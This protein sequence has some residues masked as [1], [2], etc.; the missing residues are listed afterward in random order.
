MI[1]KPLPGAPDSGVKVFGIMKL[2]PQVS[3]S[4]SAA[5]W[6]LARDAPYVAT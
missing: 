3:P 5:A 1:A 6:A 4:S 2:Q